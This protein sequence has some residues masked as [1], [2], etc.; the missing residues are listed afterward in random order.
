[1]T[2]TYT[3][4]NAIHR[5]LSVIEEIVTILEKEEES[6]IS[7]E[8]DRRRF[9]LGAGR[10]EDIRSEVGLGVWKESKVSGVIFDLSNELIVFYCQLPDVYNLIINH[11]STSEELRRATEAKIF[12]YKL[13]YLL[14]LP[15][16]D[17]QKLK[18]LAEVDELVKGTILL[19]IPDE[20]VW[21]EYFESKNA[22][23]LGMEFSYIWSVT[24]TQLSGMT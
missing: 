5:S 9:R 1:M 2:T 7:K 11:P 22:Q 18:L 13:K 20:L 15:H 21:T 8:I 24:R 14:A 19:E 4:Q 10:P 3:S 16:T 6:Q 12:R 23:R 17:P